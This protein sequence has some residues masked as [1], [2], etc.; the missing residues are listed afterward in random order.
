MTITLNTLRSL[1]YETVLS[2]AFG[3]VL[4][5]GFNLFIATTFGIAMLSLPV[6]TAIVVMLGLPLHMSMART[7]I[8]N[9]MNS[10]NVFDESVNVLLTIGFPCIWYAV[11]FLI[12][13]SLM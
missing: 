9:F 12:L 6:A 8:A 4:A 13:L 10:G 3:I 5:I 11:L 7:H 2:V 1:I